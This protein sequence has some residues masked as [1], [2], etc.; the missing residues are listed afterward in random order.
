MTDKLLT[1]KEFRENTKGC[2][3]QD[4]LREHDRNMRK[5]LSQERKKIL[6]LPAMQT[7]TLDIQKYEGLSLSMLEASVDAV[8]VHAQNNLRAEL[9]QQI[10]EMK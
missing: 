8:E 7:Q 9:R 3:Y 2:F 6:A 1:E 10:K 4:E 5:K